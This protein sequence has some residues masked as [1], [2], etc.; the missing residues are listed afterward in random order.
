MHVDGR[1][2]SKAL[3]K[4]AKIAHEARI[5]AH[6]GIIAA[7]PTTDMTKVREYVRS[8]IHEVY[9]FE[10]PEELHG[11]GIDVVMAPTG[12][13]DAHTIQAGEQTLASTSFLLTTGAHPAIPPIAG[14]KEVPF[15]TYEQI[16]D[17]DRLRAR[18]IVVGAGPIGM[19]MAQAYQRLGARVTVVGDRLLPKEESEVQEV[20]SQVFEHEGMKFAWGNATGARKEGDEIAVTTAKGEA[21]GEL[22]PISSGR[23]PTANGLDLEKA[24]VHYAA[25]GIPADQQLRTNVKNIYAAGDVGG[26]YQ[27]AHFAAW[28]AFQVVG[29]ALLPGSSVGF[30]DLVPW[31]DV[32][33]SRSCPYWLD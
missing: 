9:Q 26:G 23:T 31:G 2:P 19:E 16:F 3:L 7:P 5:A 32:H 30:T 33:R 21:R 17:N 18:M 15:I 27:F 20:M 4:A 14:L 13:L 29:N 25:K 10:T 22:L 8:A 6:Y 12:F 24:G 11:Q 28:Q 1:V